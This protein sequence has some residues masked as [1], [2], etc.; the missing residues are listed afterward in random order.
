MQLSEKLVMRG[1]VWTIGT[2]GLSV[3]LRFGSNVI[4][5]RLVVPEVFGIMLVIN[6]LR[7]GIELISDVGIGQNIIHNSHGEEKSFRDTAWTIQILRG[8]I[9]FGIMF[10]A[11]APLGRLYSLPT[12]AI[13]FAS[14]S[15]AIMGAASVSIY[16]LQ[17]R[18]QLIR[19]NL[20]DLSMDLIGSLLVVGLALYSPTIWSLILAGVLGAAVRACSTYL[21]PYGRNWFAW[22][23]HYAH[24]ILH[25]GKWIYIAS[26]LSFLSSSFDKLFLG[27]SIPLAM[28]GVYGI[29][30]NIADLPAMLSAR[31]GYSV[32]FP[33]ISRE[34]DKPRAELRK[35]LVP[36]RLK[37]LLACAVCMALGIAF[38]DVAVRI[39]YDARYHEATWMLPILLVGVWGA[40]LCSINEYALL[41]VGKPLYGAA[42]NMAKLASLA[43]GIPAGLYFQGLL[44]AILVIAFSDLCRYLII[45]FGQRRERIS[46][47]AQDVLLSILMLGLLAGLTLLRQQ[48][49]FG[50]TFDG[51]AG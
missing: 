7:S 47:F 3:V 5:S 14:I 6:T 49:G 50:T 34:K 33:L 44:G 1:A 19:L 18:M 26:L 11:A 51:A 15:L 9:L 41:G 20:F 43:I 13:Q 16:I 21:L 32:V 29:A 25:F 48:L 31:L 2:Y 39:I 30:R 27:Q 35:R 12:T 37:L 46:F 24:Q 22:Q 23:P 4:L 10:L 45:L 8:M 40:I 42:G 36:L 28:L 38:A 17:R